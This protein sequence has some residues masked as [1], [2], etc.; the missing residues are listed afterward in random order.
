MPTS[1]EEPDFLKELLNSAQKKK[2][3]Q[4]KNVQDLI[5]QVFGEAVDEVKEKLGIRKSWE[6][7]AVKG[8][9]IFKTPHQNYVL[10][11][12]TAFKLAALLN[13]LGAEAAGQ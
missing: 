2:N 9:V 5:S 6:G 8:R 10:D 11:P 4:S 13:R 3:Q 1:E 7:E 12:K